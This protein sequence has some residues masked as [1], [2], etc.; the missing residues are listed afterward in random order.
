MEENSP[1]KAIQQYSPA[2]TDAVTSVAAL[3]SDLC[4]SGGKDKVG[5]TSTSSENK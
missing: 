2:H 1:V 5:S 4:V 3:K